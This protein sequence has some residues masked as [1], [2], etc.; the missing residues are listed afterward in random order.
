MACH[1]VIAVKTVARRNALDIA[2][3]NSGETPNRQSPRFVPLGKE[4]P[5]A[6][7]IAEQAGRLSKHRICHIVGGHRIAVDLHQNLAMAD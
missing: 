7:V 3:Q 6:L 2:D 4:I 1:R 5:I